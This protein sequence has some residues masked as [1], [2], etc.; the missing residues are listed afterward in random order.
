MHIVM[1]TEKHTCMLTVTM[2]KKA[3]ILIHHI[4]TLIQMACPGARLS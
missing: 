3:H 4:S 2:V 1:K